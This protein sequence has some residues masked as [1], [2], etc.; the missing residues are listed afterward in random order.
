MNLTKQQTIILAILVLIAC[1]V[2]GASVGI[3]GAYISQNR[4]LHQS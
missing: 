4:S 1:I 3:A 2:F